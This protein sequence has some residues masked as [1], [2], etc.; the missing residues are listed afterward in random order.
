VTERG[1][2]G[3]TSLA[4]ELRTCLGGAL[5]LLEPVLDRVREQSRAAA[6]ASGPGACTACPV[7]ALFAVLRGERSELAARLVEQVAG[8]IAVLRAALDEGIGAATAGRSSTR[9][10]HPSPEPTAAAPGS[11]SV[12]AAPAPASAPLPPPASAPLCRMGGS[13]PAGRRPERLVQPIQITRDSRPRRS[14]QPSREPC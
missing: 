3:H 5:D 4:E 7:C 12:A 6:P 2:P 14:P 9:P 1:C 11:C 8:V 10:T 13:R